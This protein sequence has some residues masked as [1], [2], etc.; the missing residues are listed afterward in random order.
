MGDVLRVSLIQTDIVWEDKRA[1]L[2]KYAAILSH[3]TGDC[4]LVVFPEMFTTGFSMRAEDLAECIDGETITEVKKWSRNYNVAI[5]GSFIARAGNVCFNRGFFIEPDGSEHYYDKRHLFRMG[6]EGR[7]FV[8]GSEK[9]VVNYRGWNICLL[10]CYDLRF[11]VWC[12]NVG[13]EYD[14]LL[15]LLENPNIVFNKEVLFDRVWGLEAFGDASTV[16]VH[17][18]RIRDKIEKNS[19]NKYIETVWGAGYRFRA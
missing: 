6:E 5:A 11:P 1:N 9:L 12:R 16:T 18:Q 3:I 4:D 19:E 2:D 13:N 14:L 7:H 15:F 8:S 17:I 10:V